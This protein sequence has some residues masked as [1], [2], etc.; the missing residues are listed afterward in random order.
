MQTVSL[1]NMRIAARDWNAGWRTWVIA[2]TDG[3]AV[4]Y[5]N[6]QR[7]PRLSSN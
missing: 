3:G 2:T 7:Y 1:V 5:W 4:S 6:G